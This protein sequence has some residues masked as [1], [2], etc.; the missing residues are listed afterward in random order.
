M[1]YL[2][3]VTELAAQFPS[4]NLAPDMEHELVF[5]GH[6]EYDLPEVE[7]MAAELGGHWPVRCPAHL[8]DNVVRLPLPHSVSSPPMSSTLQ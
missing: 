3:V 4:C 8:L 6:K 7:F 5:H 1:Q 2:N